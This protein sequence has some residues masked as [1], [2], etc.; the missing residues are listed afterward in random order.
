MYWRVSPAKKS[1][2]EKVV[3]PRLVGVCGVSGYC[4]GRGYGYV[5]SVIDAF[6][7]DIARRNV[8]LRQSDELRNGGEWIRW[9]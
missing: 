2:W 7:Y 8:W 1:F 3:A 4:N 6:T 5:V 9:R